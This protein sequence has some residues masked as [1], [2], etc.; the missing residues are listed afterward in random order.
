MCADSQILGVPNAATARP[1]ATAGPQPALSGCWGWGVWHRAQ[2]V[3]GPCLGQ[4]RVVRCACYCCT[5]A[6]RRHI[7][8]SA[9]LHA[10]WP[11]LLSARQ[12]L[13]LPRSHTTSVRPPCTGTS[14]ACHDALCHPAPCSAQWGRNE[15]HP[16]DPY[17]RCAQGWLWTHARTL[18]WLPCPP[19]C[20]A[21]PPRL[22]V[23]PMRLRAR[24]PQNPARC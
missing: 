21:C 9:I 7:R 11:P 20:A 24:R 14:R 10:C 12:R 16:G 23:H 22:P 2:P 6:A 1:L 4:V 18:A 8:P 17:P 15:A 19:A 13:P 3:T 5:Q